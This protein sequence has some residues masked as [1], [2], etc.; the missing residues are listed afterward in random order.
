MEHTGTLCGQNAEFWCVKFGGTYS[1][2]WASKG[3]YLNISFHNMQRYWMHM[4]PSFHSG[5]NQ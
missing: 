4:I 5:C 1:N 3:S 2:D